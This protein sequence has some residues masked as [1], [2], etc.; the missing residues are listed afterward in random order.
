M[1]LAKE[2]GLDLVV[3]NR[4]TYPPIAKILDWGKYQYQIQ[5]SK[6]KSFRAEIKE[7]QLKIK[8]EEHDFQTKAKRAEKFLQKYGKIK[9]GVML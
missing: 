3:V 1:S 7:I 6:K 4:N 8:I 5:K 2:K 9:V